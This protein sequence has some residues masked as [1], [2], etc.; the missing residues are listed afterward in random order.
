[1]S[2]SRPPYQ[3]LSALLQY[4]DEDLL[5]ARPRIAAAVSALP[6]SPARASLRRFLE[7]F[8]DADPVEAQQRYVETFD[9]QK[10]SSLYL[11]Y[12]RHG[13]T[14]QRG[15][16]LLRLKR[17]YRAAGLVLEGGELPDY[18]PVMLEF[19]AL[20]PDG[21]GPRLLA[22]HRSGLELLRLHLTE[23]RSPYAH[24]LEAICSGLPRIRLPEL[25]EVRRMLREGPPHEEVGLQPYAAAEAMPGAGVE[26]SR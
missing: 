3:L 8:L 22:E 13:D 5:A 21:V 12:F 18:L 26:A 16:S 15:L 7:S 6:S 14:R 4:P 17:L 25:E 10:R 9:L 23:V 19:A 11:T 20:A 1:M 2:R 24:L